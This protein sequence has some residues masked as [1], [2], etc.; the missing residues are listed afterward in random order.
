MS[1]IRVKSFKEETITKENDCYH[2]C[3]GCD[4]LLST[5]DKAYWINESFYMCYD[6]M[7]PHLVTMKLLGN[8]VR[9]V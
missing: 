7:K 3:F 2:E 5:G 4:N 6:C 8:K 9:Y 1:Q